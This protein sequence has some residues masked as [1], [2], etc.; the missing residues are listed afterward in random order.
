[1]QVVEHQ[2]IS[3]DF[4][5]VPFPHTGRGS[6][7]NAVRVLFGT[8][9]A[10]Y[11]VPFY[12]KFIMKF[13]FYTTILF[14]ASWFFCTS[15]AFGQTSTDTT[16]LCADLVAP[17][18]KTN[19][20]ETCAGTPVTLQSDDKCAGVTIWSNGRTGASMVSK[21]SQ[22]TVYTAFCQTSQCRSAISNAVEVVV[23]IPKTPQI[24][25]SAATICG[26]AAVVLSATGCDGTVTWSNSRVGAEITVSPT[27]TTRYTAI[28]R[29]ASGCIS[30]FADE[31]TVKVNE[32]PVITA[33][34]TMVC[35]GETTTLNVGNCAGTVKWSSGEIGK[36]INVK[37]LSSTIYTA[38]C[39]IEN[40]QT[41]SAPVTI[42]VGVPNA[43][44]IKVSKTQL[45]FGESLS[46][47][48]DGCG[49]TLEWSDDSGVF[50]PKLGSSRSE[51]IVTPSKST[52]YSAVCKTETCQSP[53]SPKVQISVDP[54]LQKPIMASEISNTCPFVS[55]DLSSAMRS[56]FSAVGSIFA[57]YTDSLRASLPVAVPG[58]VGAGT[59]FVFEKTPAGCFSAAGK[60]T[61]KLSNCL[62]PIGICMGNPPT[63]QITADGV[64]Y[65]KYSLKVALGGTATSGRWQSNGTG[66]FDGTNSLTTLYLPSAEDITAKTV[67]IAY[68]TNDPD[69]AGPCQRITATFLLKLESN[70][71]TSVVGISKY[72]GEITAG[73]MAT[74]FVVPYVIMVEN[75]GQND[76]T[77]VQVMDNLDSVFVNGSIIV[78]KPIWVS[79][80]FTVNEAYTGKGDNIN[81]LA[82]GQII[83]PGQKK[84]INL[85]VE[86][87]MA[88]A[89]TDVFYNTAMV[90]VKDASGTVYSDASTAG[91]DTD[92]DR[93]G[94]PNDNSEPTATRLNALP[95]EANAVFVPEGFSPN[96]DGLNDI[97]VIKNLPNNQKVNVEIYGRDGALV[98]K[99]EDYKNDWDG[100][101]STT[102]KSGIPVGTYF[103]LVRLSNGKEFSRFM[104]IS[105]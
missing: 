18:I 105:R 50:K 42:Q 70:A 35:P 27:S 31:I 17:V 54:Q 79:D 61:V 98:Y 58:A 83:K 71:R 19:K 102:D 77:D 99:N 6:K 59:Y 69:S 68:E 38:Q 37:P 21:P 1:M 67:T 90:V 47:Q 22:T 7:S 84:Q 55:V 34:Q 82:S 65:G 46:L 10:N 15:F 53:S 26:G 32:I 96:G 36:F 12:F 87:D 2:N 52:S 80:D 104:T 51:I 92:P 93:N 91:Q 16:K 63:A 56:S 23:N 49:G 76:L 48:A 94:N 9:L 43:P 86:V 97:F 20:L 39:E 5:I 29:V 8:K 62:N 41:L 60:V 40:C 13:S 88:K 57:V 89:S 101:R 11:C 3:F 75:M 45:C 28:C 14:A 81:L 44:I 25:A 78:G 74:S 73:S 95:A 33:S 103:Y 4:G 24:K 85:N 30:C 64:Q 72:T 66:T 100:R